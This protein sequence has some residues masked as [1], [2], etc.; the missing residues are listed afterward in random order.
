MRVDRVPCAA[1]PSVMTDPPDA[2]GLKGEDPLILQLTLPG[3]FGAIRGAL[4]QV[5]ARLDPLELTAD[6]RS[7]AELVLAEVLNN[8]IEH[9]YADQSGPI[10]LELRLGADA[11]ACSVHDTGL[12]MPDG[13][14][15]PSRQALLD[16]PLERLPEGGFGWFLIRSLTRDIDYVRA[17]DGNRLRFLLPLERRTADP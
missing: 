16:V 10:G 1:R 12:P 5:M 9:A 3:E 8:V 6:C 17:P 4:A 14:P 2:P 7:S 15:P 11:L 13:T